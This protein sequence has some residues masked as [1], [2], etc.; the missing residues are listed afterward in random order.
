MRLL[1]GFVDRSDAAVLMRDAEFLAAT[2]AMR[3]GRVEILATGPLAT[4]AT[5]LSAEFEAQAAL[6]QAF[7]D[8]ERAAAMAMAHHRLLCAAVASVDVLP[9]R[10]GVA[11]P[12]GEAGIASLTARAAE[13]S[14]RFEALRG[15]AEYALRVSTSEIGGAGA[16]ARSPKPES[17]TGRDYLSRRLAQRRGREERG[18]AIDQFIAEFEREARAVARDVVERPIAPGAV[19]DRRRLVDL[20]LLVSRGDTT[21]LATLVDAAT[22][23]AAALGLAVEAI[24]PWPP[25]HFAAPADAPQDAPTDVASK[26]ERAA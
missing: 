6:G 20:A 26:A 12:L 13:L 1:H 15:A 4:V 21:A 18:A 14:P 17:M 19:G 24:G 10:L 9:A 22:R 7:D 16:A 8:P 11:A 25:F 23:R 2:G 5:D 3:G